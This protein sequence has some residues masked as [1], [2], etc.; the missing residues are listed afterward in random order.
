MVR[1]PAY[2]RRKRK[3]VEEKVGPRTDRPKIS[4]EVGIV[5]EQSSLREIE[6]TFEQLTIPIP[7]KAIREEV[8]RIKE[9]LAERFSI[10]DPRNVRLVRSRNKEVFILLEMWREGSSL[11][12]V[13]GLLFQDPVLISKAKKVARYHDE[14]IENLTKTKRENEHS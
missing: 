1:A 5:I 4:R 2:P 9:K 13:W 10:K 12:P 6:R 8:K 11:R 3:R 7:E 14:Q